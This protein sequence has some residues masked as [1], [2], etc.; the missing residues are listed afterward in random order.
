MTVP[1]PTK[2]SV[3]GVR[4][5]DIASP[6]ETGRLIP[7]SEIPHGS[8]AVGFLVSIKRERPRVNS[9]LGAILFG[10]TLCAQT[11]G[12]HCNETRA[13][14]DIRSAG[15]SITSMTVG[16]VTATGTTNRDTA[17]DDGQRWSLPW[18]WSRKA[19]KS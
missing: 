16:A 17:P 7:G 9:S 3:T 19:C 6:V 18:L 14:T 12:E 11:G 15:R 8:P 13:P 1:Y 5:K 2:Y 10:R 4:G